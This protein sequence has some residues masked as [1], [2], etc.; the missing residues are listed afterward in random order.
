MSGGGEAG[1]PGLVSI[2]I[3]CFNAGEW[4]GEA[5]TSALKQ[6]YSQV[7]VLVVDDGSTDH[8]LEVVRSFAKAIRWWSGPNRG[9]SAAR[10]TGL[11]HARGEWVQFLD[12]DDL[13]LDTCVESKVLAS[14]TA[15]GVVCCN[16]ELLRGDGPYPEEEYWGRGRR[17]LLDMLSQGP[18]GSPQ[19]SQPLHRRELLAAV[20]G[21]RLGLPCAQEYDLHLR[22]AILCGVEFWATGQTGVL[23]RPRASSVSRGADRR[24]NRTLRDVL[25]NAED[26]LRSRGE[27]SGNRKAAIAQHYSRI[28]KRMWRDGDRSDARSLAARAKRLSPRWADGCYRNWTATRVAHIV[29]LC[30][31]ERLSAAWRSM[32]SDDSTPGASAGR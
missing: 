4:V 19:T 8:S 3:P 27:L 7:E 32:R 24:M 6:T 17:T 25:A 5:I 21:F 29:G 14:G 18:A 20:G 10:N 28:A 23:L 15:S 30:G 22:L 2:I 9:G 31:Y 11:R 26:L 12:A 13:L 16:A 1:V